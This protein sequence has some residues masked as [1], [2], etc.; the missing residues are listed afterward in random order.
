MG[1]NKP[2]N[3][4]AEKDLGGATVSQSL[5]V[6]QQCDDVAKKKE[7]NLKVYLTGM[8]GVAHRQ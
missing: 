8:S 4:T 2:G 7:A 6:S 5:N 3:R 1:D